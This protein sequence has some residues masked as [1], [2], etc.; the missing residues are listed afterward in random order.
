MDLK[1]VKFIRNFEVVSRSAISL[2]FEQKLGCLNILV[3]FLHLI[4]LNK[5]LKLISLFMSIS[6]V[7]NDY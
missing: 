7:T 5:V 2:A 4:I 6:I 3:S 1:A